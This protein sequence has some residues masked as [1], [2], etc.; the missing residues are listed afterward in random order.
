MGRRS[1][2]PYTPFNT[3]LDAA[4]LNP[5]SN[6]CIRIQRGLLPYILGALQPL[7][8]PSTWSGTDAQIVYA[9]RNIE[10]LITNLINDP[11]GDCQ[12]EV[13]DMLIGTTAVYLDIKP[14][15]TNG[16][17]KA[18]GWETHTLNYVLYSVAG[19]PTLNN[20]ALIF[21]PGTYLIEATSAA[22]ATTRSR[23]A[24]S[25]LDPYQFGIILGENG[26]APL[27]VTD[28]PTQ[29]TLHLT[30]VMTI[31]TEG[32]MILEQYASNARAGT[33]YGATM[34]NANV[35]DIYATV[36]VTRLD[37]ITEG[38]QGPPGAAGPPGAT[39]ATG[40][41]GAQGIQGIQGIQ[42][43]QGPQGI[44][45]PQ[46]PQGIQGPQGDTGECIC[47]A[48]TIF[49]NLYSLPAVSNR[50]AYCFAALGMASSYSDGIKD[51]MEVL[52]VG[53]DAI[54]GIIESAFESIP[55]IGEV[56]EYI[57]ELTEGV[58]DWVTQN[59]S[60][61]DAIETAKCIFYCAF[62]SANDVEN[63]TWSEFLDATENQFG[64]APGD[65]FADILNAAYGLTDA[66]LLGYAIAIV[67]YADY[68]LRHKRFMNQFA[69]L[70]NQ[71][72]YFDER[73]CSGC[74]ENCNEN[75]DQ[76]PPG[77][78]YTWSKVFDFTLGTYGW[79]LPFSGNQRWEDGVGFVCDSLE[80]G[81][82]NLPNIVLAAHGDPGGP[83]TQVTFVK[84]FV[85]EW[86]HTEG[87]A[88]V[89]FFGIGGPQP[90]TA[91]VIHGPEWF[92]EHI[93]QWTGE[94]D[95]LAL[96]S[97]RAAD[98]LAYW[99]NQPEVFRFVIRKVIVAGI[100]ADRFSGYQPDGSWIAP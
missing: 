45:G 36:K 22:L 42:G 46:G 58:E 49:N 6:A 21:P 78:N 25:N 92:G 27:P 84:L 7:T 54:V 30:G 72:T 28:A 67:M 100:G 24:L 50:D 52:D 88:D 77:L 40:A 4:R 89:S 64:I 79:T 14:G 34:A 1:T 32:A 93:M 85:P 86:G 66:A 90:F 70:A 39:G 17:S 53:E 98:D 94:S 48:D 5:G 29:V 75:E 12:N 3:T 95:P 23:L 62:L 13:T 11:Y 26:F 99:P 57:S 71:A 55:V 38:L 82:G 91:D 87:T 9:I 76:L 81:A 20:N 60:D 74:D 35:S 10:T 83:D 16:G 65:T 37:N 80:G 19:M 8:S 41:T 73:S 33:G 44:Q 61:P 97:L 68:H 96:G 43:P 56:F 15:N 47:D 63:I 31:A 2:S 69:L 59:F 18:T 51:L